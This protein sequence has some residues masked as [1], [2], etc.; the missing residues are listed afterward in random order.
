MT[1]AFALITVGVILARAGWTNRS[2]T[3]TL[4]TTAPPTPMAPMGATAAKPGTIGALIPLPGASG[5]VKSGGF[6]AGPS[7]G[8]L[9][10]LVTM[11]KSAGLTITATTNGN[12]VP[13]SYHYSGRAFDA[14]G[15]ESQM[16]TF[17]ASVQA[18]N[19]ATGGK[20]LELIH[21]PGYA[22]KNGKQVN[23]PVVYA[24]V[25]LG[26]KDHVHVAA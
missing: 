13:G 18:V 3:D 25:W 15:T 2:V 11:A 22:I 6:P 23:G 10:Q 5:T 26:H 20:I 17:A 9:G 19:G 24:A 21:N 12:H 14:A 4:K 16:A 8:L 7:A 1:F